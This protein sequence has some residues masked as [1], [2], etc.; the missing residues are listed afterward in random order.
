MNGRAGALTAFLALTA[1]L[2]A[3][4]GLSTPWRPLAEVEARSAPAGS[5]A[6]SG[7]AGATSDLTPAPAPVPPRP[8][9]HRDF[10][11]AEIAHEDAF[12]SAVRPPGYATILVGLLVALILGLTPLGARLGT[13]LAE[14]L[15]GGP[16]RQWAARVAVGALVVPLIGR[17]VTLPFSARA[18]VVLRRY[19]LSTQTWR[20]WALDQVK[21]YALSAALLL[22]VL[23][24]LYALAARFPRGWWLPAAA[25][26]AALVVVVS[27]VFPL[28][29]EPVFNRFTPLPPGPLRTSLLDLA[30]RDG[31]PVAE[32]LVADASRRTSALNAYVSGFG[33][34]R[35]IVVYDTLLER[36]TPD[37]VRAVAAHEL[38]HAARND[39]LHG[40]LV[41]ALGAAAG[42]CLLYLALTSPSLLRRAGAT[43]AA[44]P[45][46]VALLL[47]VVALLTALGGPV[48]L[49]VSRRVEARA[50]VHALALTRDPGTFAAMQRRLAV[51]NLSDLDP[52]RAVYLLF[53]SHPSAPQR[54]A[55][56]RAWA[57][58]VGVPEPAPLAR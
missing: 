49:L 20:S 52:P 25:G 58:I 34:T 35:R 40:T 32:V 22:L 8:D 15:G 13:T 2:V 6:V 43:A 39:V 47:A 54:I 48:Q 50:D 12:H 1:A 53:S 30:E 5:A 21:A 3:A 10:R 24:A 19:G 14:P 56:A 42:V 38:G 23:L 9:P 51:E 31:V 4:I 45:R 41:G 44:D 18:E 28:I 16:G 7:S 37:E 17:L 11:P 26:G 27:F 57:R 55:L 36:G 46:S 33:S 29:V